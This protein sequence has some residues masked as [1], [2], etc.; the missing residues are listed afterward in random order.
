MK[1][2]HAQTN[3]PTQW[4]YTPTEVKLQSTADTAHT[5]PPPHTHLLFLALGPLK[6]TLQLALFTNHRRTI[7]LL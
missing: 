1:D 6:G 5:P 4:V 3:I 7:L 2:T